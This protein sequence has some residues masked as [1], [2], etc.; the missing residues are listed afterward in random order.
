VTGSSFVRWLFGLGAIPAGAGGTRIGWE[1]PFPLWLALLAV[2]L[3]LLAA[4]ASYRRVAIADGR[5][6]TLIA[7]R[8]ATTVLLAALLAG[9][10]LEV[11]RETVE[12]D[13]V[14]VLADRSRSMEVQDIA[15]ASGARS[16]DAALRELAAPGSPFADAGPEHRVSWFGFADGIVPLA[17]GPGGVEVGEATGDRTMIASSIERAL[18]RSSGRAISAIVLLT[19]GRTTEPPDRALVRRLQADGIAVSAVALG[20][21]AALGDA[22]ISAVEAPR[23][24]FVRDLVPVEA[25]VERRG[26][27]R[28]RPLF[29][30][31][32]DAA[33]GEVVDRAELP[34]AAPGDASPPATD[35]VQLIARP[36]A[37]GDA[38]WEVRVSAA[39]A[40]RDLLPAN[41]R[42][43]VPITLVDRPM[44][45]LYVDGYPRWEY[46]YLKNLL[47]RERSVESA[48]MLLSADRDFA[49]EGN[50]PISRLPRTREEFDRFDLFVLGDVPASFFTGEQLAELRRAVGDRGAGLLWIGGER[51]TPRTWNGTSL[52]DLLPFTGPF[53][54]ERLGGPVNLRPT[55]LAA[56]SGVLR[57]ADDP[58]APFPEELGPDGEEWARLEWAQRIVPA[59]LKPTAEVLAESAQAMDGSNAPLVVGMRFGAGN[60]LYVAT[61]E[62][63][64]W[65]NGRG[66]AYPERFW[67]QLLRSLARPALGSGSEEVRIAVEPARATVGDPVRVEVELPAGAP[68]S[69]VV[70]EAVPEDRASATVELEAS[71]AAGGGFVARWT[72]E[73]EGRWTI[74]PR[75]P[76]LAARAG[77][78]ASLE[79]VRSDRELR[80]AEI[81]RALLESLARETGGRVVGPSEAA[82]LVRSLPNRSIRTEDP[83][84][85][86]LWNSPAALIL[87]LALLCSE[88]VLRRNARLA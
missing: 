11:P 8:T 70:L 43:S 2:A 71:P 72:P 26:P 45:V 61:D 24:A 4:W 19:D 23:R 60:A 62:V 13:S 51:S 22:A 46:R 20:A 12:P 6:R 37:A 54:L 87:L 33:T 47:Q 59:A 10:L 65:R 82:S 66:E 78:G 31:L 7:L 58:K 17:T 68:P 63:W 52:E 18:E 38:R 55:A 53:D 48:V 76:A 75:D 39:D 57:L 69:T 30:E 21:D 67:V 77:S 1:H 83:I 86:R 25:T 73:I 74:R 44:R 50:T 41:D 36:S 88:W 15:G 28:A 84:Q 56:R 40:A 16:R 3:A 80:D 34:P 5:R 42:R 9:P 32:V 29:V 35:R 79:T 27:S 85:D 81:D 49:Q 64:R 14:V